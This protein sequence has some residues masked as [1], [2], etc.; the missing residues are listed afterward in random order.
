MESV[1][2]CERSVITMTLFW[3]NYLV[4]GLGNCADDTPTEIGL[5]YMNYEAQFNLISV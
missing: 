1:I 3:L 5:T 2:E 4:H